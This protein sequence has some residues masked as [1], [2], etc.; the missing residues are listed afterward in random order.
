MKKWSL[1]ITCLF[2]FFTLT[3][4]TVNARPTIDF[5]EIEDEIEESLELENLSQLYEMEEPIIVYEEEGISYQID[6]YALYE[7]EGIARGWEIPF[8][9]N[10]DRGGLLV[11]HLTI[12]NDS[13]DEFF[14]GLS[15]DYRIAGAD[16]YHSHTSQLISEEEVFLN[17][18]IE[19]DNILAPGEEFTGFETISLSSEYLDQALENGEVNFTPGYITFDLEG[20]ASENILPDIVTVLPLSEE[21][22]EKVASSGDFY[23]DEVTLQNMGS[24]TMLDEGYE[25]ETITIEDIDVTI[26]GYQITEFTPAADQE[27][28]FEDFKDG[29]V[30]YTIEYTIENNSDRDENRV[31]FENAYAQMILNENIAFSN[32]GLLEPRASEE[33]LEEG[34]SATSYFVFAF[35]KD[36]YE[37]YEGR[38]VHLN[39]TIND[40]D[41]RA[42]NDYQELMFT[43]KEGD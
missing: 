23:P 8:D 20:S 9:D 11:T 37:L 7:L 28:R 16:R 2:T 5:D 3:A 10:R 30:L 25:E 29:V 31:N 34:E 36:D 22:E 35:S 24:K 1:L 4:L 15:Q 38:S 39:V 12:V 32:A 43:I 14:V 26:N 27:A 21:A 6:G 13:S 41:F 19:A 17:S 33:I 42:I 40:A 18:V